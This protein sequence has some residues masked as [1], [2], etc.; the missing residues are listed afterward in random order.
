MVGG[1][2]GHFVGLDGKPREGR[3]VGIASGAPH[4]GIDEGAGVGSDVEGR[5]V[6]IARGAPHVGIDEGARVGSDVGGRYSLH[7]QEMLSYE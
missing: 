2:T 1:F 3:G 7:L 6:G 4:V 5:G